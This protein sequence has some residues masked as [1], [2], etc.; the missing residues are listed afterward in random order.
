M[1]SV[2]SEACYRDVRTK[3]YTLIYITHFPSQSMQI[4][5][6][7]NEWCSNPDTPVKLTVH[8][9][10]K[11]TNT[12]RK[13]QIITNIGAFWRNLM[14]ERTVA[15]RRKQIALNMAGNVQILYSELC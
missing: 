4:C 9:F 10:A 14:Q 3:P 7:P 6:C 11:Q 12:T 1:F 5:L 8:D 15:K 13:I 2:K